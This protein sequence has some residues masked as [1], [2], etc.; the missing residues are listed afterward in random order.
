M[1]SQHFTQADIDRVLNDRERQGLP[2]YVQDPSALTV[3]ARVLRE[4]TEKAGE[5]RQRE[6]VEK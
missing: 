2:R 5:R 6:A 3:V 4:A 1:I